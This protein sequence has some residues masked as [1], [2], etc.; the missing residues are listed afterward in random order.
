MQFRNA[1]QTNYHLKNTDIFKSVKNVSKMKNKKLVITK[2]Q[3]KVS[4]RGY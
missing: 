3:N 4:K 2:Y 1:L